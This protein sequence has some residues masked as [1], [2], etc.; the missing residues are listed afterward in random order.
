MSVVLFGG[1]EFTSF[2]VPLV[3][4]GRFFVVEPGTPPLVSV[5]T[6]H[7]GEV[8]FEVVLPANLARPWRTGGR[9]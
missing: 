3:F 2:S 6:E 7:E 9:R 4:G 8:R 1:S 5:V